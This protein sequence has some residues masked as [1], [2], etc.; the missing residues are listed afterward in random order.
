MIRTRIMREI[1][2]EHF[3]ELQILW[4][5]RQSA[6]RSPEYALA[7][8]QR[9]DE[10]IEAHADGLVVGG[11]RIIPLVEEGLVG[12]D[13]LPV[14]ASAYTLLRLGGPTAPGRAIDAFLRAEGKQLEGFR[15]ALCHGPIDSIIP[16][17]RQAVNDSSGLIAAVSAE[18]LTFHYLDFKDGTLKEFLTS[19]EAEVRKSGW[20]VAAMINSHLAPELY[21]RALHDEDPNVRREAMNA[22]GWNRERWLLDYCRELANEPLP[23]NWDGLMILAV[24]GKPSDLESVLRIGRNAS[25]GP[26]RFQILGAFGHPGVVED[27]LKEIEGSDPLTAVAAGEA[28]TKITGFDITSNDKVEILPDDGS[29]PDEFERG[30]LDEAILPDPK[31]ARNHWKTVKAK[32]SQGSRWCRGVDLSRGATNE[33]LA[34]VDMESRWEACLR[35]RFDGAGRA[36][37]IDLEAFPQKG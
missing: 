32:L 7:A 29:E 11:E 24:L 30:F 12:D 36:S 31:L 6:I 18:A 27:F 26:R 8:L 10:R 5:L 23:K 9:L 25:L 4:N 2:E 28:F 34:K 3:E 21:E 17:L 15:Q 33:A 35:G 22:A 13:W 16:Q 37:P 19:D 14:F 20:R 1:L